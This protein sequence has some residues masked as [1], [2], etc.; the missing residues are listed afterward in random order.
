MSRLSTKVTN[1][2][3]LIICLTLRR[4]RSLKFRLMKINPNF[5]RRCNF[6]RFSLTHRR[7]DNPLT[8][9]LEEEEGTKFV[10][11]G[12]DIEMLSTKPKPVLSEG[13]F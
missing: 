3:R 4:V 11:W 10:E 9:G 5:P 6:Y 12:A 2:C 8:R 13:D 1:S 7:F